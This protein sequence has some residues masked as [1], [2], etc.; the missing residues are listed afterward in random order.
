MNIE[1]VGTPISKSCGNMT[2]ELVQVKV[3]R[4]DGS[5]DTALCRAIQLRF[6]DLTIKAGLS[7]LA[8]Q[9]YLH[10]TTFSTLNA[11]PNGQL[12]KEVHSAVQTEQGDLIVGADEQMIVT[13]RDISS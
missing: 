4:D 3:T 2:A 5:S 13:P 1:F 6:G 11:L 9:T 12:E 7:A 10:L 8:G